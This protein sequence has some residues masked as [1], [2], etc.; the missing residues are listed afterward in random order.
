M[1]TKV[2]TA[3]THEVLVSLLTQLDEQETARERAR[4]LS[5]NIYRLAHYLGAAQDMRDDV[6]RGV[7]P[8]VAFAGMFTP[9][10]GMHHIARTLRF[11]L[12]VERGQWVPREEAR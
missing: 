8:H 9:T 5:P 1:A 12:D 3:Y 6:A 11:P 4:R 10:R 7:A 2:P